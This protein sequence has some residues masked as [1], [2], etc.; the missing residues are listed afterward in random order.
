MSDLVR[1]R[2][3]VSATVE[4][5]TAAG[6]EYFEGDLRPTDQREFDFCYQGSGAVWQDLPRLNSVWRE[7][8][9]LRP[10]SRFL[11]LSYDPRCRALADH[12]PA[13]SVELIEAFDPTDVARHLGRC[14]VGFVLRRPDLVNQVSFPTKIGESLACGVALVLTDIGWDPADLLVGSSIARIVASDSSPT[15]IARAAIEL[16]DALPR[17][18]P[19]VPAIGRGVAPRPTRRGRTRRAGTGGA[20]VGA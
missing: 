20:D 3:G 4:A 11:I 5:P 19:G 8:L 10:D 2:L 15:A 13:G 17:V 6:D 16:V 1:R 12:L 14:K 18:R 9:A 7:I